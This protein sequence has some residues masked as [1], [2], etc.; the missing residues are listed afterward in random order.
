MEYYRAQA[1]LSSCAVRFMYRL[2]NSFTLIAV[3]LLNTKEIIPLNAPAKSK[4]TLMSVLFYSQTCT[5]RDCHA[6]TPPPPYQVCH[7]IYTLLC[8]YIDF[9]SKMI[10]YVHL[11]HIF[12]LLFLIDWLCID[13]TMPSVGQVTQ[14]SSPAVGGDYYL[15]PDAAVP[16]RPLR[17]QSF[18]TSGTCPKTC[19]ILECLVL[20]T[21]C[22]IHRYCGQEERWMYI[23]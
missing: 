8:L 12:S 23:L 19:L 22:C 4:K 17:S 5:H 6:H 9:M 16:V 10:S 11:F 20:D 21:L 15:D 1:S 14:G 7:S 13:Y 3:P 18:H 2:H